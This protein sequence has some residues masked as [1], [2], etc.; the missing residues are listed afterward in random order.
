MPP[1]DNAGVKP[2]K[3]WSGKITYPHPPR[4]WSDKD[5]ERILRSY[6]KEQEAAGSDG[7]AALERFIQKRGEGFLSSILELVGLDEWA[8]EVYGW[9]QIQVDKLFGVDRTKRNQERAE[10]LIRFIADRAGI[11]VHF[12]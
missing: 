4:K 9:I 6:I 12:Q 7:W 8:E 3:T 10:R 1:W 11:E 2:K 5:I